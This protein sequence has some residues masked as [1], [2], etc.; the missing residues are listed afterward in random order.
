MPSI[1]ML[2]VVMLSVVILSVVASL[3]DL[4][5][6]SKTFY[7]RNLRTT[8]NKLH[9]PLHAYSRAVLTKRTSLF[10]RTVFLVLCNSSM[11]EL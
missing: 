9:Y 4:G 5:P 7:V 2:N 3:V 8:K 10:S 6:I 1:I 11:N